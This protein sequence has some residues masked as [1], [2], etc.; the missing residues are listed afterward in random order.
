MQKGKKKKKGK[1]REGIY[2]YEK[3][4]VREMGVLKMHKKR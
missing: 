4:E 1:Q 2:F 3:C